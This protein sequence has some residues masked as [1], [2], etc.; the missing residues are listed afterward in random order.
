MGGCVAGFNCIDA[1]AG[2]LFTIKDQIK[3][4]WDSEI[5]EFRN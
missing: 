4:F 2:N 3:V 1:K 5:E